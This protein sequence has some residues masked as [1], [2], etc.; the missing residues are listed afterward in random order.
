MKNLIFSITVICVSISSSFGQFEEGPFFLNV[1]HF[2]NLIDDHYIYED[3]ANQETLNGMEVLYVTVQELHTPFHGWSEYDK[4]KTIK[5][6]TEYGIFTMDGDLIYLLMT[7]QK[8][9]L[10]GKTELY[11]I[12]ELLDERF[13]KHI[14]D[15]KA[16]IWE[17]TF[18]RIISNISEEGNLS[19]LSYP[20]A[21]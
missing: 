3:E 1:N 13:G 11:A 2:H 17:N 21:Q 19:V 5:F 18:I 16:Y 9:N 20:K 14:F 4:F 10:D 8:A 7:K 15:G 6:D 12:L